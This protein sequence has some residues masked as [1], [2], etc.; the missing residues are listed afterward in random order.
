MHFGVVLLIIMMVIFSGC[1]KPVTPAGER[2]VPGPMLA[3]PQAP[4]LTANEQLLAQELGMTVTFGKSLD[5]KQADALTQ[6]FLKLKSYKFEKKPS[7]A[8]IKIF[9]G[10]ALAD[11]AKYLA[12]RV[13]F[14]AASTSEVRKPKALG[15]VTS[16]QG[17]SKGKPSLVASNLS[18]PL[19]LRFQSGSLLSV[20]DTE[21][22]RQQIIPD[23]P[24]SGVIVISE[25]FHSWTPASQLSILV[26]EARHSDCTGGLRRATLQSVRNLDP[27][28]QLTE[29]Q[30]DSC[31]HFH[32]ACPV[33][34]DIAGMINCDGQTWG[35][36]T[37]QYVFAREL[38]KNCVGCTA[39]EVEQVGK[40]A[41]ESA[42]R[43]LDVPKE[44][45]G[46]LEKLDEHLSS[47]AAGKPDMESAGVR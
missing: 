34:H 20:I 35:S 2:R 40:L 39:G 8:Y 36:H 18:I 47:V 25:S 14:I 4:P 15:S 43:I 12:D 46:D 37:I 29:M 44:V 5:E 13:H 41:R 23:H 1:G 21:E 10:E 45:R 3:E 19:W 28:Q 24:R 32:V 7:R 26:H 31:G 16:F 30:G 22:P 11:S 27:D 33:G 17:G 6:T 38:S 42:E 9:E